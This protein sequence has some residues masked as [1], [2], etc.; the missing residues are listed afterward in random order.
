MDHLWRT[1]RR[2]ALV[3]A[4]FKVDIH[5][6]FRQQAMFGY[7]AQRFNLGVGLAR[8]GVVAFANDA[9]LV[10][11]HAADQRVWGGRAE[12]LGGELKA[13][14]HPVLVRLRHARELFLRRLGGCS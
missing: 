14:L 1:C 6:G 3:G 5:G 11:D 12:S 10:Y 9:V 4:R 13:A 2:A 8:T 7:A